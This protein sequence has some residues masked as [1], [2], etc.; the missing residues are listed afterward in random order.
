MENCQE[1]ILDDIVRVDFY[2]SGCCPY[3]SEFTFYP[4]GGTMFLEPAEYG[5]VLGEMLELPGEV[6]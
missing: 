4:C 1:K 6:V 5:L 3:F 2:E